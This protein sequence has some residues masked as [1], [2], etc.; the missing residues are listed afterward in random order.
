APH[1][2]LCGGRVT[3][4]PPGPHGA[5]RAPERLRAPAPPALP[6]RQAAPDAELLAVA[7]GVLEAL[8]SDLA[9]PTHGL[10][11][12]GGGASLGEEEVG[13]DAQAVG[14]LLP[15]T[16]GRSAALV[17]P[18]GPQAPLCDDLCHRRTPSALPRRASPPD[19]E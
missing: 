13:V 19:P 16:L 14:L 15:A 2:S 11:L 10:G 7:Q 1:R 5:P 12:L 8:D 3:C 6:L 4:R 9:A 17:A 18:P